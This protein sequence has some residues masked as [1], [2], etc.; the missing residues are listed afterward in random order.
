MKIGTKIKMAKEGTFKMAEEKTWRLPS[1]SQIHQK[2]IYMWD[3][4]YKTYTECWKKT[5][6]FPK[7]VWLR[8]SWCSGQVSCLSLLGGR[9]EFRTLDHQ[10][11]PGPT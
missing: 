8:G 6:D 10:R 4:I 11:P 2:Y 3:N 9:A 1:S 5:S 7:D